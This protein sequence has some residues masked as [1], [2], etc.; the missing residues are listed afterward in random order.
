MSVLLRVVKNLLFDHR[1]LCESSQWLGTLLWSVLSLA[2]R[3]R[4]RLR[5][6]QFLLHILLYKEINITKEISRISSI[7]ANHY[8]IWTITKEEVKS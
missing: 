3:S 8:E 4:P 6:K 7:S 1:L 2:L 5:L